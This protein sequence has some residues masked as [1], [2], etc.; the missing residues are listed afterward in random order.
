M[1]DGAAGS[2]VGAPAGLGASFRPPSRPAR[3]APDGPAP[4]AGPRASAR[5]GSGRAPPGGRRPPVRPGGAHPRA[6][7]P[8]TVLL[9]RLLHLPGD[10]QADRRVNGVPLVGG[11]TSASTTGSE[12]DERSASSP[13][14]AGAVRTTVAFSSAEPA[15]S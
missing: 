6:R 4:R 5:R 13:R 12:R 8:R 14:T 2:V 15:R 11:L 7:R 3:S 9:T 10:A 1:A